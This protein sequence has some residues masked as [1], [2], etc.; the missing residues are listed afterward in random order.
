MLSVQKPLDGVQ[1]A[2]RF[3]L[4]EQPVSMMTN[5]GRAAADKFFMAAGSTRK[6]CRDFGRVPLL[7]LPIFLAF[8]S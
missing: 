6:L 2:R 1:A 5:K 3:R 8:S 7:F 4:A